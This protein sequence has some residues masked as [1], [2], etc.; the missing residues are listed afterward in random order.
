MNI[1]FIKTIEKDFAEFE[2][3][4]S[5]KNIRFEVTISRN[6]KMRNIR[7]W[8]IRLLSRKEEIK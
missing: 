8:N 2:D 4:L 3:K 1:K 6:I 5:R 7:T